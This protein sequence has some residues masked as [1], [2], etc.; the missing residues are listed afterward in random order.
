MQIDME[1]QKSSGGCINGIVLLTLVGVYLFGLA[2]WTPFFLLWPC[3]YPEMT[4]RE[5]VATRW[6][7]VRHIWAN[8]VR[9]AP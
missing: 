7:L 4:F 3:R 6:E 9:K 1:D 2:I 8:V 5:T